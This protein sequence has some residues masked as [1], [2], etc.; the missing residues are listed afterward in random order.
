[1]PSRLEYLTAGESHGPQLTAILRGIPAGLAIDPAKIADDMGRRQAGYGRGPRMNIEKDTAV[2]KGGVRKGFTLGSPIALTVENA[3]YKSWENLMAPEPGD[4]PALKLVTRPRPGH[5]DLVGALKFNHADARNVLERS[6]AR[7]TAARVAVGAICRAFLAEFGVTVY[8]HV[9]NLGGAK[10]DATGLTHEAIRATADASPLRVCRPEA[11]A[12]MVAMIDRAKKEGD[13]VGGIY[14][15]VALGVPAGLGSCMNWDEKL[16]A[17]IAQGIIAC[18]AI[19]GVSI[20]LGFDVADTPGS[21]VHD[22][23]GFDASLAAPRPDA[24][25]ATHAGTEVDDEPGSPAHDPGAKPLTRRTAQ[26]ARPLPGRGPSGGFYHLGNNAGGIEGGMSNGEPI[27]VRGAMKPIA[28]LMKP[29]QSVD[30][31]TKETFDAVRERS[32]VCAVPAA[33]V[34]GEAIVCFILAQAFLEK[35]GGDSIAETRRNYDSYVQYMREF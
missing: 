9:V 13:T 34:V 15:V 27:V 26:D 32:D 21:R 3:D 16:D 14:E 10:V 33:G 35:F 4:T 7:E 18:Q 6:S 8:S 19:K 5:A 2:L 23:I 25:P 29:L 24:P 17:R 1:M 31:K 12:E 30:L 20:G 11:E 28:T 22:P